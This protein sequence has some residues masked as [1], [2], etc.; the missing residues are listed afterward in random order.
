MGNTHRG[1]QTSLGG[2]FNDFEGAGIAQA[3]RPTFTRTYATATSPTVPALITDSTTG[4]AQSA[5]AAGVGIYEFVLPITLAQ[6][7]YGDV[8]TNIVFGHKFKI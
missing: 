7:A 3:D 6:L 8:L 5:A 1:N 4:T 2:M